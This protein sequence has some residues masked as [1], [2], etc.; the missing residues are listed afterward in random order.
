MTSLPVTEARADLGGIVQRVS[1]LGERVCLSRNGKDVAAVVSMDDLDLLRKLE[2][3]VDLA[4]ARRALADT[5]R[6]GAVPWKTI[7]K[8]LGL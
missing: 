2:D 6:R 4:E 5:R 3:R 8:D 7:K 1:L